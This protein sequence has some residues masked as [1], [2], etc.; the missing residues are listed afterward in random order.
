MN[1]IRFSLPSGSV[2]LIQ[3]A[4]GRA[5]KSIPTAMNGAKAIARIVS[6]RLA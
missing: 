2:R 1:R 5:I 6:I 4:R 3:W